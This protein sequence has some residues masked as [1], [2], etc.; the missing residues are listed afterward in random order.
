MI[1]KRNQAATYTAFKIVLVCEAIVFLSA[2]L[3]HTGYFGVPSLLPAMIVEGL[4]GLCCLVSAYALFS[5]KSW[6]LK[7]AIIVQFLIL[8]GVLLGLAALAGN[9]GLRTPLNLGLHGVMLVLI[10]IGLLLLA[11]PGT[12]AAFRSLTM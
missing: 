12:R 8:F 6:A 11:L 5:R 2:A 10:I 1:A 9:A 4:C 3:L 7:G